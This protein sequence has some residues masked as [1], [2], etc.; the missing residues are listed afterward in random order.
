MHGAAAVA[1]THPP[2]PTEG[3]PGALGVQLMTR[4]GIKTSSLSGYLLVCESVA[5]SRMTPPGVAVS[6]T[7]STSSV[8]RSAARWQRCQTIQIHV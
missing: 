4:A 5:R 7:V 2:L 8:P 3:L 6:E 1:G